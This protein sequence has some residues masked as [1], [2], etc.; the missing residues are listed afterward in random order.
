M[1]AVGKAAIA[2]VHG[3]PKLPDGSRDSLLAGDVERSGGDGGVHPFAGEEGTKWIQ[4]HRAGEVAQAVDAVKMGLWLPY[5]AKVWLVMEVALMGSSK[6]I[7]TFPVMGTFS[8]LETGAFAL[9][10][11]QSRAR[12]SPKPSTKVK[13]KN[14]PRFYFAHHHPPWGCSETT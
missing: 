9:P 2:A 3:G 5:T 6:V 13:D 4:R 8:A 12:V 1:A 10:N 11:I 7:E 14:H